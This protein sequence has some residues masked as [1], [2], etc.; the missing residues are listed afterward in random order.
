MSLSIVSFTTA[1][2]PNLSTYFT[3]LGGNPPY[4]YS[5]QSGGAGG[6]IDPSLGV[7]TSP[8]ALPVEAS[9]AFDTVVVTDSLGATASLSILIGSPIMLFCDILQNFMQIPNDHIYVWDQKLNQPKDFNPYIAVSVESCK[10]FGNTNSLDQNGNSIQSVNMLAKL[11]IDIIS[12]GLAARD[13]KEEIVLALKSDYSKTQQALNFF[14][15]GELPMEFINLS[16]IDGASIP[17]RFHLSVNIQ[18]SFVKSNAV[19]IYTSIQ[20]PEILTNP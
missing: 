6:V 9:Q 16:E 14:K 20:T 8:A 15:I 10:P 12:R 7:Y 5:V 4:T 3:G 2:G 13:R 19:P 18:Y 17:Y 1:I 11:G